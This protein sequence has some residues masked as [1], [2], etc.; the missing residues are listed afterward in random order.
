VLRANKRKKGGV[1]MG[2][3]LKIGDRVQQSSNGYIGT[4]V[5]ARD[6]WVVAWDEG[7]SSAWDDELDRLGCPENERERPDL[8]KTK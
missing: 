8:S 3:D 1:L 4:I 5:E 7:K 6:D 2:R